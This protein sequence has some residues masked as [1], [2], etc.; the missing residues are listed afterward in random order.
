[1]ASTSTEGRRQY[2]NFWKPRTFGFG[3]LDRT[4]SLILIIQAMVGMMLGMA[5]GIVF[6]AVLVVYLLV[7]TAAIYF[8]DKHG[9]T[10]LNKLE[11][12]MKFVNN[13]RKGRNKFR[14][15]L[16]GGTS[17]LPAPLVSSRISKHDDGFGREFALV[18]FPETA[19]VAVLMRCQ[20]IGGELHDADTIDN[21][22]ASWGGFGAFFSTQPGVDQYTATV[23]VGPNYGYSSQQIVEEYIDPN[24]PELAQKITRDTALM[25]TQSRNT[26]KTWVAVT[27]QVSREA[28]RMA[29]HQEE[30]DEV[31]AGDIAMRLPAMIERLRNAG[32]GPVR[33]MTA[34]EITEHV[35]VSY[36]P[37]MARAAETARSEGNP[38]NIE[39]ENAGPAAADAEWDYYRHDSGLSVTYRMTVGPLG[40]ITE[41]SLR[42]IVSAHPD[43]HRKRVVL[44]RHVIDSGSTAMIAES[45]YRNA[46]TRASAPRATAEDELNAEIAERV[47]NE[48]SKGAGLEYFTILTTLTVTDPEKLPKA[49]TAFEHQL[50][51][52]ASI[53]TRPFYGAEEVGFATALGI[54]F[55]LKAHEPIEAMKRV[56]K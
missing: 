15:A 14:A 18:H 13:K 9:M 33:P 26:M 6:T 51:P 21:M 8:R 22:V 35:R 30:Y 53:V 31:L 1:M 17:Q 43:I 48:V 36:D 37:I 38:L 41:D 16:M 7:F 25:G 19:Q 10:L 3:K 29:K 27:F 50:A 12:R 39:W 32:G 23:E 42:S 46:K 54:G 20:P 5:L 45:G 40:S 2:A 24:A 44:V 56:M 4:A 11:E 28:Q 47:R 52:T 34:D 55:D 49:V